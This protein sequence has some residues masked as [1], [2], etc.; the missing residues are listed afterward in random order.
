MTTRVKLGAEAQGGNNTDY[1]RQDHGGGEEVQART[2]GTPSLPSLPGHQPA[3]RRDELLENQQTRRQRPASPGGR[4]GLAGGATERIGR[5]TRGGTASVT[6]E[7]APG[8]VSGQRRWE[9]ESDGTA[10]RGGGG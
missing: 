1:G 10:E 3:V 7:G 8:P 2:P 6:A 9:Q 5:G 4:E